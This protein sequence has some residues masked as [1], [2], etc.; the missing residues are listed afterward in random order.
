MTPADIMKVIQSVQALNELTRIPMIGMRVEAA[1]DALTG[2]TGLTASQVYRLHRWAVRWG[3]LSTDVK[4]V[5]ETVSWEIT[6][7]ES[8]DIRAAERCLWR[9][10]EGHDAEG[11]AIGRMLERYHDIFGHR[12]AGSVAPPGPFLP[13]TPNS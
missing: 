2:G 7:P 3:S 6:S 13:R 12:P 1:R 9:I 8:L 5:Y 10:L 11:W 4:R